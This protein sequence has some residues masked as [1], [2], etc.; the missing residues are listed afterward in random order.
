MES[1]SRNRVRDS[2]GQQAPSLSEQNAHHRKATISTGRYSGS[3]DPDTLPTGNRSTPRSSWCI[4]LGKG[5]REVCSEQT[6]LRYWLRLAFFVGTERP[7]CSSSRQ[8]KA[9]ARRRDRGGASSEDTLRFGS[10]RLLSTPSCQSY[11]HPC[12]AP[13]TPGSMI[14]DSHPSSRLMDSCRSPGSRLHRLRTNL[15]G[16]GCSGPWSSVI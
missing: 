2:P 3:L 1:V 15:H 13:D 4:D 7:P 11:S 9:S 12:R 6:W 5:R 14:S 16:N 8:A 10:S